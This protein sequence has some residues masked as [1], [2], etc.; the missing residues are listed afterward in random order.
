VFPPQEKE[1][2]QQASFEEIVAPLEA[3]AGRRLHGWGRQK[4]RAAWEEDPHGF[5]ELAVDAL[6][7][8]RNPLALLV[9]MVRAGDLV[10]GEANPE[11]ATCPDCGGAIHPL[12]T[13]CKDCPAK[14]DELKA[15]I[16]QHGY[17]TGTRFAR[18]ISSGTYVRDPL[19]HDR[20][21]YDVPWSM[22]THDE[23]REALRQRRFPESSAEYGAKP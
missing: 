19:G 2:T 8:G 12:A 13:G 1:K 3:Q 5:L 11:L 18:N 14:V 22:P 9:Q 20:A 7:R 4:C 15:Y 16:A 21:P 17:P 6:A 23:V 10:N